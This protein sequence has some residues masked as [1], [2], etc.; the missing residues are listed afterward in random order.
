MGADFSTLMMKAEHS[1][2]TLVPVNQ[3]RRRYIPEE[4]SFHCVLSALYCG[5]YFLRSA[6]LVLITVQLRSCLDEEVAL[7]PRNP[8]IRP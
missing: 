3:T 8:R 7:R 6:I 2:G 1:Y 5:M 4:S